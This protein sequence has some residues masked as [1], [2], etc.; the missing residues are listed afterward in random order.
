M[1]QCTYYTVRREKADKIRM[2]TIYSIY[3]EELF[4]T[5]EHKDHR[6][7]S[8]AG[9]VTVLEA[10]TINSHLTASNGTYQ[11]PLN[12]NQTTLHDDLNVHT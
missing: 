8:S 9:S 10:L 3:F 11:Q 2:Y 5:T 7:T 1:V 12:H 4:L 6:T